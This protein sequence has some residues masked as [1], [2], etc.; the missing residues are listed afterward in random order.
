[1]AI[2]LGANRANLIQVGIEASS[3]EQPLSFFAAPWYDAAEAPV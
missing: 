2:N 3:L 1:M